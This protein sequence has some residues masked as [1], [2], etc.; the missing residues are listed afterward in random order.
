MKDNNLTNDNLE[1]ASD[2][3]TLEEENSDNEREGEDEDKYP[4]DYYKNYYTYL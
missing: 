3:Y 2:K 1:R 4:E